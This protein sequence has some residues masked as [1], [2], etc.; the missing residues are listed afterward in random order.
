MPSW[1]VSRGLT[2]G[3]FGSWVSESVPSSSIQDASWATWQARCS[4]LDQVAELFLIDRVLP[5]GQDCPHCGNKR[6][7]LV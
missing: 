2:I 3:Q 5:V 7:R 1:L 6:Q 4:E